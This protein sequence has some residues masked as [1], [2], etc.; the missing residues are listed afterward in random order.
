MDGYDLGGT[1]G[2]VDFLVA[3]RLAVLSRRSR[4]GR[5]HRPWSRAAS[6][7]RLSGGGG[8]DRGGNSGNG[9]GGSYIYMPSLHRT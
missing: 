8:G 3:Q 9:G 1:N 4:S 7:Q 6:Q 5:W 2:I